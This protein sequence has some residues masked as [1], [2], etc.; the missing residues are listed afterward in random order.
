M[1]ALE[2]RSHIFTVRFVTYALF[3]MLFIFELLNYIGILP[4][5]V[6]YTW[7]G[8]WV[9]T[10]F[11][12]CVLFFLDYVF[13]KYAEAELPGIIWFS[14]LLIIM[15]DFF[16]D[17]LQLYTRWEYYDSIAHF[18]NGPLVTGPLIIFFSRVGSAL[19]WRIPHFLVYFLAF[20]TN[21][22]LAVLYEIEEYAEDLFSLSNRLGDGMDTGN[23]LLM[24]VWGSCLT[25]VIVEWWG[26][27]GEQRAPRFS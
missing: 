22:I 3:V 7:L 24:A 18:L 27:R 26:R 23:D 14:G 21:V 9:S 25:I 11:V 10:V 19:H 20:S 5:T 2:I 8:R 17:V 1:D 12:F 15:I 16:G 4:F 13:K 6:T